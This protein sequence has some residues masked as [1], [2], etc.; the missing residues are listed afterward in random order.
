MPLETNPGTSNYAKYAT[1]NPLMRRVIQRFL[2]RITAEVSA[3]R[4]AEIIDV[5][6]GEGLVAHELQKLPF[7]I[8]YRGFEL[9]PL[10]VAAAS[11]LNPGLSFTQADLFKLDLREQP[12]DLVMMLEVL[13]HLDNPEQA[14]ARLAGWTRRAG[15][16][17]VPWEPWFRLGNLARGK[18]LKRLG[19]HPEHVQA[20]QHDSFRALL[21]PHF[22]DVRVFS[23]FPWLI[24]VVQ[25]P[26]R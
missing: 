2:R 25:T 20:Y 14:V 21:A 7:P 16:F 5:G 3:L 9:N 22:A 13:E 18:Y 26:R 11:A 8:G 17:S 23:C 12:A 6:C 10:A 4:P 1:S 15:L 24:G 19:N